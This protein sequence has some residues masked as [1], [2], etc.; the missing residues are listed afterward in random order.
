MEPYVFGDEVEKYLERFE[1][2]CILKKALAKNKI[3]FIISYEGT[4]L[5]KNMKSVSA[6]NTIKTVIYDQV[7]RKLLYNKKECANKKV[8]NFLPWNFEKWE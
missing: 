7:T 5:Y 1:N 3:L 8:L 4:E 2:L 6:A